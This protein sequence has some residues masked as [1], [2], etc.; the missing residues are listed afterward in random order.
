MWDISAE[1]FSLLVILKFCGLFLSQ[2]LSGEVRLRRRT[3]RVWG[4]QK[5]HEIWRLNLLSYQ[6]QCQLL[7]D[8]A[9]LSAAQE[10][11]WHSLVLSSAPPF[12]RA[13]HPL[14]AVSDSIQGAGPSV[15]V[16][17][18]QALPWTLRIGQPNTEQ[19]DWVT[20]SRQRA[21]LPRCPWKRVT[22]YVTSVLITELDVPQVQWHLIWRGRWNT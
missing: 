4:I 7:R 9:H 16:A 17:T 10:P 18:G 21:F 1:Y 15:H 19:R 20:A 11:G 13:C 22:H 14:L 3:V 6:R 12:V 8:A 5:Q 2:D